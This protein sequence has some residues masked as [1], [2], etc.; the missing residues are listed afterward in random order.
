MN[1]GLTISDRDK[2]ALM[3]LGGAVVLI[4]IIWLLTSPKSSRTNTVTAA[5]ETIEGAEKRLAKLRQIAANA[6]ADQHTL[7]DLTAELTRREKGILQ[8]DTVGQAQS[9]LMEVVKRVAK[10]ANPPVEVGQSELAQPEPFG[11]A[12]GLVKVTVTFDCRIEQLVNMLSDF[13]SAP[14]MV[15][16]DQLRVSN[17]NAKTKVMNVRLAVAGVIPKRLIP[18]RKARIL[19]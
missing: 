17:A 11:D 19:Q 4:G 9:Q 7:S 10:N 15:A 1:A 6:P 12:Y 13:A 18:V 8:A 3:I 16:T 2:R 5:S 14:E